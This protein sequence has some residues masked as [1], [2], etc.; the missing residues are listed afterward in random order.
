LICL[1]LCWGG[2]VGHSAFI[3]AT[4]TTTTTTTTTITITTVQEAAWVKAGRAA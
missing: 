1:S 2:Y 4:T 3:I